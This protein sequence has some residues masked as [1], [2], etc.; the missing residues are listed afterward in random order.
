MK[1]NIYFSS[2]LAQF[3]LEW[4]IVLKTFVYKIKKHIS[5]SVIFFESR[6]DYEIMWTNIIEPDRLVDNTGHAYCIIDT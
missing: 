1:I 2:Y 5:C 4:E 6:A 3:V